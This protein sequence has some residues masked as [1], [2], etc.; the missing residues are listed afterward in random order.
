MN[1]EDYVKLRRDNGL[2]VEEIRKLKI[3][4]EGTIYAF[5]V[6]YHSYLKFVPLESATEKIKI[7]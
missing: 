7:W 3:V 6:G 1:F 5:E 2:S 4:T